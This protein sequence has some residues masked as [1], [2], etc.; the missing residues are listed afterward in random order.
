VTPQNAKTAATIIRPDVRPPA[1]VHVGVRIAGTGHAVPEK[2]VTNDDL[3]KIMDTSDEWIAQR[4][5]IRQRRV[6][7]PAKGEGPVTLSAE[8]LRRALVDA[9]IDPKELDMV[10]LGSVTGEMLCPSTACRVASMVGATPAGAY[11]VL[12]ACCGFVYGI[13]QA[14]ALIRSG[15]ARTVGV[16]GCDCLFSHMDVN[17]RAVAVLFGDSAG[18]AVLRATDDTSRGVIASAMHSD[19]SRWSDLYIPNVPSDLPDGVDAERDKIK[20]GTLQ[21]H[22]REVYKFAVGTFT[23]LIEQTLEKAGLKADDVA[24][25]VCHQSNAR[26]LESARERLGI[27]A[28]KLYINIDRFGNCSAGSVPV[29]FDE[30]RKMGKCNEGELV[31]FVAFGGGMTWSSS[32]WRM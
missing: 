18:A 22:G 21:M 31:M 3:A 23:P 13:N 16:I 24:M 17:N 4:T 1:A 32:L 11:D 6:C 28:E 30:L 19:G 25:Y 2:I 5:G 8:A 7:D 15:Q 12:A 26:M 10:I 9:N 29:A 20:F 27:P 14:N